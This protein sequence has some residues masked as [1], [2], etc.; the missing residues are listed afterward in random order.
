LPISFGISFRPLCY[1]VLYSVVPKTRVTE[2][3]QAVHTNNEKAALSAA[4]SFE[5]EPVAGAPRRLTRQSSGKASPA[6]EFH[7]RPV[8]R[9]PRPK[10]HAVAY[11]SAWMG[12]LVL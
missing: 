6:R 2:V 7:S 10:F 4:H 5:V 11:A 3:T 12:S 8:G 9:R 1:S